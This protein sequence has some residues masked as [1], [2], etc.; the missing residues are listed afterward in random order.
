MLRTLLRGTTLLLGVIAILA[1]LGACE[2]GPGAQPP[3][4]NPAPPAA[5]PDCQQEGDPV[6][7][8]SAPHQVALDFQATTSGDYRYEV[9]W[10]PSVGATGYDIEVQWGQSGTWKRIASNRDTTG[11]SFSTDRAKGTYIQTRVRAKNDAGDSD[12]TESNERRVTRAWTQTS[13]TQF[14]AVGECTH[15]G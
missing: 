3:Q 4:P 7:A 2:K 14:P 13:F 10:R 6:R 8:P 5:A 12:W 1:L 11:A 15:A 9:A